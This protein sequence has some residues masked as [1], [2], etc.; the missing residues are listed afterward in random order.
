MAY[1]CNMLLFRIARF[2]LFFLPAETAHYFTMRLLKLPFGTSV[3]SGKAAN[4]ENL[5]KEV[6]GIK[7]PNPIGLAA[8]FDKN[9]M[10]IPILAKLGFGHIEIGTVTPKPQ[11][12]NPKPRLFRLPKDKALVNRMGFN[13]DGADVIAAR[14]KALDRSKINAVIGGNIGK[15]KLTPNE[16]A[17]N[18]YLICFEKLFDYVDY[19]V[20]NVSSPNTPGLRELQEKESLAGIL[21]SIQ[22][23]NYKKANPKPVF[24][25]ISPDLHYDQIDEIIEVVKETGLTGII[26]TNTTITREGLKTDMEEVEKAGDG[27]LSGAPLAMASQGILWYLRSKCPNDMVLISSGGLMHAHQA[28]KRLDDGADL[29]QIYTGFIYEG[30]GLNKRIKKLLLEETH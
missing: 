26:A 28:K 23:A 19:F 3:F 5:E 20:V 2:F 29:V 15:N 12:G 8:G 27:G 9:A 24:L 13:N 4:E 22:K 25:K 14:L 17:V 21:S 16:E 11:P 10:W 30:P 18:D 6:A 7:F 1:L